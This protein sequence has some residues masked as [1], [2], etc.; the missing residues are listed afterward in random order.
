MLVHALMG[1][2]RRP[3]RAGSSR[4]RDP[5]PCRTLAADDSTA[6][7]LRRQGPGR[8][9][10]G[11]GG[12]ADDTEVVVPGAAAVRH[13]VPATEKWLRLTRQNVNTSKSTV[14]TLDSDAGQPIS[15]WGCPC[16]RRRNSG[17]WA[18]RC[19]RQGGRVLCLRTISIEGPTCCSTCRRSP[20]CR[21]APRLG[22][23]LRLNLGMR[24]QD[25]SAFA[26][27]VSSNMLR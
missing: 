10:I 5:P 27:H 6:V 7:V 18:S 15:Y 17:A 14:W 20:H 4:H 9:D 1:E 22:A 8:A 12:Y 19:P 13:T 25:L 24:V 26:W 11:A 2:A 16:R 21:G 23:L 3:S